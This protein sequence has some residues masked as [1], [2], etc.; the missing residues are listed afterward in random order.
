MSVLR[1]KA[2]FRNGIEQNQETQR[3]AN[4]NA[5]AELDVSGRGLGD[6]GAIVV[7][8]G[9]RL[10]TVLLKALTALNLE[11]NDIGVEGAEAI[12]ASLKH[13]LRLT[14]LNMTANRIADGGATALANAVLREDLPLRTLSLHGNIIGE[15]GA[16][17]IFE[18]LELSLV[19]ETLD[20]G[21][22]LLRTNGAEAVV[23]AL[24]R[25]AHATHR[26]TRGPAVSLGPKG[27]GTL[28][29]GCTA[30]LTVLNLGFCYLGNEG[31]VILSKALPL[32]ST[33]S[34]LRIYSNE[35]VRPPRPNGV[36]VCLRTRTRMPVMPPRT[37]SYHLPIILNS[38]VSDRVSLL[39]GFQHRLRWRQGI[40]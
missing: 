2:L 9:F 26:S 39:L 24:W 29:A 25:R 6:P 4:G 37:L 16:I 18:R 35:Y 30:G 23:D 5:N 38:S 19:L 15:V 31:A 34:E 17:A 7:A 13:S 14:S 33:L 22:N 20:M 11:D 8:R 27:T 1:L 21:S 40:V 10:G 32:N 3:H 12:A 36:P 28:E